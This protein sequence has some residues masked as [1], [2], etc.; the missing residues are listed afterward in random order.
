VSDI[1]LGEMFRGRVFKVTRDKVLVPGKGEVIRDVVRHSGAVA[2]VPL[3]SPMEVLL[4]K[5]YRFAVNSYLWEIPAGTLESG[6][7]REAC[8]ARELEE[9]TGYR[10]GEIQL[11]LQFYSTPGFCD[12]LMCLFMARNLAIGRQKLDTDESLAVA[13]FQL[14]CAQEMIVAGE[15]RDAKTI[16]GLAAVSGWLNLDTRSS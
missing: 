15:I 6:E 5:Q 14:K 3:I 1:Q 4:I 16:V 10:A 12:E 7:S 8:A 11:L 13:T 9:E 2:I